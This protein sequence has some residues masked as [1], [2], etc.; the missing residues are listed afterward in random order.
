MKN[1]GCVWAG[2]LV[3]FAFLLLCYGGCLKMGEMADKVKE[4]DRRQA[5]KHM[6][7]RLNK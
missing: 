7:D 5:E 3:L 4:Q 1:K 2:I 6:Q